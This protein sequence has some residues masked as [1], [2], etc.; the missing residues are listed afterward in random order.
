MK[1]FKLITLC[2]L[3]F[4]VSIMNSC[5]KEAPD[6]A[7]FFT[8]ISGVKTN[9]NNKLE[10]D[11]KYWASG[12]TETSVVVHTDGDLLSGYIG[13][14]IYGTVTATAPTSSEHGKI[15]MTLT[16]YSLPLVGKVG[17]I[18]GSKTF[19][20]VVTDYSVAKDG[21]K[22]FTVMDAD[23]GTISVYTGV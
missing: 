23:T 2:V 7:V 22:T 8:A 9:Q 11:F 6:P 3:I 15:T 17:L 10:M 13:L 16:D 19:N 20:W 18:G 14:P 4:S 21:T 1:N 12:E 5:K